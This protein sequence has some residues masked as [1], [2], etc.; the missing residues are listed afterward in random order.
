MDTLFTWQTAVVIVAFVV[1]FKPVS[2]FV[3]RQI[4]KHFPGVDKT[5]PT[6]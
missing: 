3:L 4:S 6:E 2:R 1:L 5:P